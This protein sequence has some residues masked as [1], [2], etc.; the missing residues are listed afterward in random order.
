ME[1][2]FNVTGTE[3]K[4]LAGAVSEIL[5]QP[6][7]YLGAPTFAY[8]IGDY[9]IDKQGTDELDRIVKKLYED[10]ATG[11]VTDDFFDKMFIDYDAEQ[12]A[13]HD[14]IARLTALIES[15]RESKQN[16]NRFLEMVR[17]Y[18]DIEELTPEVV[19]VFIDKIVCH[20]ANGRWG[21]NRRQQIDIYWNFIGLI[22]EA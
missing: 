15:E 10:N 18:T 11:R 4:K 7:K 17:K 20:Q 22:E 6:T 3:R 2:K 1:F 5:N 16:T 19:R 13:L 9:R 14:M 8:E 21:K 12:K